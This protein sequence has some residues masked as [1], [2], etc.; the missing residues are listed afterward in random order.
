MISCLVASPPTAGGRLVIAPLS[1]R[2]ISASSKVF[3]SDASGLGNPAG[4]GFASR[5][6]KAAL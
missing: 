6:V 2:L 4:I 1:M 3:R 5:N